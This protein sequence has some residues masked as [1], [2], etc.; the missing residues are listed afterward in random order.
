MAMSTDPGCRRD[1]SDPDSMTPDP[2]NLTAMMAAVAMKTTETDVSPANGV[3]NGA[4]QGGAK[5]GPPSR[6]HLSGRK[7]SLQERGTYP[8]E[9][10]HVSP[11]VARRP[12]VESKQVSISDA[13]DC[14]QLNQ[15]KLKSEI[16]KVSLDLTQNTL[17]LII[18]FLILI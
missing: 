15:Y 5:R 7:L 8:S 10:T 9:G 18:L 11:R 4:Q 1:D 13:E 3:R 6:A 16:G 12:T 14:I 17:D 2:S